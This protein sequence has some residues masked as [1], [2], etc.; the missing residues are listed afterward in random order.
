MEPLWRGDRLDHDIGDPS[1]T[2]DTI[3]VG[4][5]VAM[6]A[7]AAWTELFEKHSFSLFF[8]P[9]NPASGINLVLI[10]V[11]DLKMQI[12]RLFNDI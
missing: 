8:S 9:R 7:S 3:Y 6:G 1:N 5:W 4:G 2:E 11:D 10:C 12:G